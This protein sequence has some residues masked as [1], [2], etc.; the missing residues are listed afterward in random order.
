MVLD[1][2]TAH[3][4]IVLSADGKQAGRGELMHIVPDNPQRFDPVICVMGKRGFLSGRFYFQVLVD[5]GNYFSRVLNEL[6]I[7]CSFH[8]QFIIFSCILNQVAVGTK[9]FWDLG[10]V[11]ESVNR[12]G[13]IT[14]KPE[15]GY[16]TVRLRSGDEY[17]A[18]DSPSVLL[19]LK[20][21]PQTVGVFTDYEGGTVSFFNVEA[22]SHIY[23][24][25]GCLFSER[26]FPFF[27]PGVCDEG[28]NTAPLV[29]T[30]VNHGTQ[31]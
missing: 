14:S 6:F 19:S 18:L 17:R 7:Q 5:D 8:V 4:N 25:T 24:F 11:K 3:P 16:W 27:S 12:K 15:N 22:G 2:D 31:T 9:T 21:K 1:Q 30:P 13:M 28:K 20:D 23:T 10:M 29:I 26:I